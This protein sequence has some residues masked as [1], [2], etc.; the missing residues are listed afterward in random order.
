M[1]S[2]AASIQE[3][4]RGTIVVYEAPDGA[5]RVEV[6]LDRETVWLSL[7]QIAELFGRDNS[8]ISRHLRNVFQTGKSTVPQLLQKMQ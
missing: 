4:S 6:R 5:A 1:R 2:M 7:G 3:A 8:V